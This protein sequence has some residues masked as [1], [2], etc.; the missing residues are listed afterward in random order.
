LNKSEVGNQKS[1]VGRQRPE[2]GNRK[3]E[4]FFYVVLMT[5]DWGLQAPIGQG[6]QA[7]IGQGLQAPLKLTFIYIWKYHLI[8]EIGYV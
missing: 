8:K 6:L 3:S 5:P 2:I 7:P 4:D 1:E